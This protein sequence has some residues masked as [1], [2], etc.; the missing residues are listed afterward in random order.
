MLFRSP[1]TQKNPL[2]K[3]IEDAHRLTFKHTVKAEYIDELPIST[4]NGVYGLF[5][6]VGGNA[7]SSIQFFLTDST[8]YYIR[9]ALY[10]NTESNADS[11]APVI[12]FVKKDAWYMIN[13]LK[14][15]DN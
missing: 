7:A 15:K 12:D 2:E 10:F 9:C 6:D 5:Y 8:R 13:S 4:A 11:L 14:W 1:I 3:L